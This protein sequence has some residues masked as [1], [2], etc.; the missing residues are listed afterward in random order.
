MQS[1]R[2]EIE[3]YLC[4]DE[5]NQMSPFTMPSSSRLEPVRNQSTNQASEDKAAYA[6]SI[7]VPLMAASSSSEDNLTDTEELASPLETSVVLPSPPRR[8][9]IE[10]ESRSS[11]TGELDPSI[12]NVLITASEDFAPI[13]LQQQTTDQ[14]QDGKKFLLLS[15]VWVFFHYEES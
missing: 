5:E 12:R 15:I 11:A 3:V 2:G 13:G 9:D 14:N 4:Q 6:N 7:Q 1:D 8:V 10:E